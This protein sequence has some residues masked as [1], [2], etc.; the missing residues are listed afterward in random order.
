LEVDIVPIDGDLSGYLGVVTPAL[1]LL[2]QESA[3]RLTSYVEQGGCWVATYLTG[4]V[5]GTNRCWCGG[6]PGPDL[7][8]VFGLWNEE[9]DY[10]FN[11]ES[12]FVRG[13]VDGLS[14][15]M[16]ATDVIE[17]LHA[18]GAAPMAALDS[19]F[20]AGSPV[21]LRN[22]WKAGSTYYVGARL[23]EESLV[24]FYRVLAAEL[25]LP[26]ENL[27]QGVVRKI[28]P[29]SEGPVEFLF[30]YTKHEVVID[31]GDERFRRI[32]DGLEV[33]G[34]TTL[35]PYETLLRVVASRRPKLSPPTTNYT[36][37]HE[38]QIPIQS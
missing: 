19:D 12:V 25:A 36:L 10:L 2:E 11:D 5:D 7:R 18:E 29:G 21:I 37:H 28:R 1:Y 23:D 32:S 8:E 6:F 14:R 13:C 15:D 31:F 22:R 34:E 20:Y 16:R 4:Y 17:H 30:N 27:P 33:T 26:C 35:R 9:V 38:P 24:S 3:R